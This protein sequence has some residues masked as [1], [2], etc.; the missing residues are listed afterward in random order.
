MVVFRSAQPERLFEDRHDAGRRLAVA[1]KQYA[2][3]HPIVLALPRGGVPVAFEVAKALRCDLDLLFVRK[4]GAPGQAELGIGAVVDGLHPQLVMN[5]RLAA[6]TGASPD[7]VEE[8]MK[9]ELA[10]ID[11]RRLA[12]KGGTP[13]L[14]ITGRTVIV[15][16]DGIATGGTVKAALAGIRRSAPARL[17]LAVPVAPQETIEEMKSLAD[18]VVCLAMPEPFQAVGLHYIDFTQTR[19]A[20]VIGLMNRSREWKTA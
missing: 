19:D 3:E 9:R 8:E 20:E 16:D 14:E 13:P 1:L 5:E 10:E 6:L 18:E 7:Y 4:I 12:Y 11:R 2:D 15:V 17:V